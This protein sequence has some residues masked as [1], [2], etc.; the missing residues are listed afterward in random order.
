MA[1]IVGSMAS[2]ADGSRGQAVGLVADS[3]VDAIVR[4][5]A[6]DHH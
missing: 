2:A 4:A 6:A 1:A 5:Y 3:S